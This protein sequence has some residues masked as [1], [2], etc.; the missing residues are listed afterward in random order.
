MKRHCLYEKGL[1]TAVCALTLNSCVIDNLYN[2][3]HPTRYAV[4]VTA[5]FSGRSV[6]CPCPQKYTLSIG[7][8]ECS[9][10]AQQPKCHPV[11]FLP[12]EYALTAWNVCEGMSRVTDGGE[13]SE[14]EGGE[15]GKGMTI[16][17]NGTADGGIEPL[18]GYLFTARRQ[19]A[20]Q[21]DDTLRVTLPMSQRCRDLHISLTLTEGDP[22]LVKSVTGRLGGI[23]GAF[24]LVSQTTSEEPRTAEFPL[25]RDGDRITAD[26]RL[27]GILGREQTLELSVTFTDRP[28]TEVQTT[29]TDLTEALAGFGEKMTEG[30]EITGELATP[31][32][33]DACAT[34]TG[35]ND[36]KG[37]SAD[38]I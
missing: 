30:F 14:T 18:P 32:G 31:V 38:A 19:I 7:S 2:T 28:E 13:A 4:V 8:E 34:I 22:E 1:L 25:K 12:G 5:D 27:L 16:R 33:A 36:V 6:S 24:D 11:L 26:L 29:V 21:Q 15:E 3:P 10:P 20:V 9:A 37:D 23:A 17:V 35:W